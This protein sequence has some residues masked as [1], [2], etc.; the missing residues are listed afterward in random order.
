MRREGQ[1][2]VDVVPVTFPTANKAVA[3][4]HRHHA[5]LPGGF[6]WF[7]VGAVADGRLVGVAIAGRPTNRNND[8]KQTV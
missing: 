3:A 2:Q 4:W 6:A 7:C 5:P 8:D 1:H